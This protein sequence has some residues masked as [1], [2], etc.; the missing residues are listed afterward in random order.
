MK[1]LEIEEDIYCLAFLTLITS[2]DVM[3]QRDLNFKAFLTICTQFGL[4]FLVINEVMA[5]SSSEDMIRKYNT[6]FFDR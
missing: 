6:T 1:P 2:E 4:M 3:L 5:N